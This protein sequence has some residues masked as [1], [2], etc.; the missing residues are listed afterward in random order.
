LKSLSVGRPTVQNGSK[1]G[2]LGKFNSKGCATLSVTIDLVSGK[3]WEQRD[4]KPDA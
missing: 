1:A 4:Q 3:S 2:A